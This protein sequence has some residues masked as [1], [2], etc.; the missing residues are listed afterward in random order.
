MIFDVR[1]E[2]WIP[3]Q[4][5]TTGDVRE[6]GLRELLEHAQDYRQISGE[7][8]METYSMYRFLSVFLLRVYQPKDWETK[9]EMLAEGRFAMKQ[10]EDYFCQCELAGVSFDLFDA[11]RP[12]LQ[13]ISN[14]AYDAEKNVKSIA[15]LDGTR[16]SG[17]N[18]IHHDHTLEAGDDDASAGNAGAFDSTDFCHGYVRR[19]SLQCV[20][21]AANVF[22]ARR[23]ESF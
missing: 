15:S 16:A 1:T 18:S 17:N 22:P 8:A 12:F 21:C 11:K 10:V 7:N 20:W 19:V 14:D 6:V 2:P 3:V 5:M 23:Q 4:D 9:Y 13:A